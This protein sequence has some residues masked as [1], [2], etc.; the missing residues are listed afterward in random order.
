MTTIVHSPLVT[1][2]EC[3]ETGDHHPKD[4]LLG[5]S[6]AGAPLLVR[7]DLDALGAA[8]DK[9]TVAARPADMWRYREFLPLGLDVEAISLGENTTPLVRVPTVEI[10]TGVAEVAGP[11]VDLDAVLHEL[12]QGGGV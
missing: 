10:R 4:T 12:L 5:L 11:A 8:V 7:Y 2:L 3:S 6:R 9:E 1:H